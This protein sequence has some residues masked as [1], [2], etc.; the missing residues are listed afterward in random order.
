MAQWEYNVVSFKEAQKPR[1]VGFDLQV[2]MVLDF[3]GHSGWEL[4]SQ[5]DGDDDLFFVFKR[6]KTQP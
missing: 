4:V 2:K 6:P 3:H 1:T 5:I